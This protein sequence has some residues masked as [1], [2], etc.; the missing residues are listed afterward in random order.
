LDKLY[1]KLISAENND[2]YLVLRYNA[3]EYNYYEDPLVTLVVSILERG[4]LS[5]KARKYL[6]NEGPLLVSRIMGVFIPCNIGGLI[7]RIYKSTVYAIK[8]R[9]IDR[10]Y[11]LKSAITNVQ[12]MLD[13]LAG[14]DTEKS[15][16]PKKIIFLIDELDRCLPE[17][18]I[19]V[20]ERMHHI[21]SGKNI[22]CVYAVSNSQLLH[23]VRK[24]FGDQVDCDRYMKK[25]INYSLIL[26]DGRTNDNFWIRYKEDI[27]RFTDT[28]NDTERNKIEEIILT[29]LSGLNIR[30]QDNIWKERKLLYKIIF[31]KDNEN[32][33]RF[34][35]SIEIFMLAMIERGGKYK[36]NEEFPE[37]NDSFDE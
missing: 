31:E 21:I 2:K 23:T 30:T 16:N 18:Q 3:W 8:N 26:D 25:F 14:H 5:D 29:A 10:F 13:N 36:L 6:K 1:E 11:E 22:V 37:R 19:K 33:D 20:L 17:Y 35:L 27:D 12:N 34:L 4:S 28:I 24:I 7:E 15:Q 9:N 32:I